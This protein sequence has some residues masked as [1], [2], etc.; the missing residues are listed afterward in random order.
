MTVKDIATPKVMQGLL[1]E[2]QKKAPQAQGLIQT[3]LNK[4]F[5]TAKSNSSPA[6][7][8][9][10]LKAVVSGTPYAAKLNDPEISNIINS[11]AH[12]QPQSIPQHAMKIASGLHV[13]D[14]LLAFVGSK[15]LGGD[16]S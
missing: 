11:F 1:G 2:L 14:K 6:A 13:W 3:G 10:A 9:D 8:I 15:I 5:E 7:V 4:A 12:Q 16:K